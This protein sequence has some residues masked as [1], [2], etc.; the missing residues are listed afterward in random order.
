MVM[1]PPSAGAAAAPRRRVLAHAA[2]G[3]A[4]RPARLAVGDGLHVG[5]LLA[6][7]RHGGRPH[8]LHEL[9]GPLGRASHGVREAPVRVRGIAEQLGALGAQREDLADERVVVGR[10]G[11]A[12]VDE[13]APGALAQVA[14]GGVGEE[15]V[16]R[17]ARVGDQPRAR[18]AARL[19]V[20]R[21]GLAHRGGEP[22]ELGAVAQHEELVGLVLQQV[23]AEARVEPGEP[24]VD[25]RQPHL[26]GGVE[27]RAGAHEIGV[28]APGEA[29]LLGRQARRVGRR[30]RRLDA[31]EERRVLRDAVGERREP[32][33]HA[34]LHRLELGGAHRR[35][36]DTV[37]GA[38]PV[39]R[40]P[41]ALQRGDRV[42][43]GRRRG[44]G[45]D[46]VDLGELLGHR[47]LERRL[48]VADLDAVERRHTAVRPGPAGEQRVGGVRG[49]RRGSGR[50][51]R[52]V[53][54]GVRH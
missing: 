41:G 27:P 24:L 30:V 16:D 45:G 29:A 14:P 42:V 26:G 34:A 39:E 4:A 38:Y 19:R 47:G 33:C 25:G 5:D 44:V 13:H 40:A 53:G 15:R 6:H 20:G 23:L 22:R 36:P 7:A 37:G 17:R 51:R 9:H 11:V 31:P 1:R 3:P 52:R 48:E 54:S 10:A 2:R 43:E 35:A 32:R 50:G 28:D 21:R 49:C 8:G 18:H 12:A 46:A